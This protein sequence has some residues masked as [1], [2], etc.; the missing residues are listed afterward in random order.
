MCCSIRTVRGQQPGGGKGPSNCPHSTWLLAPSAQPRSLLVK[1]PLRR[2]SHSP[3]EASEAAHYHLRCPES[4]FG[5]P[6]S[7]SNAM[8]LKQACKQLS[9][10]EHTLMGFMTGS[11]TYSTAWPNAPQA[12]ADSLKLPI[13]FGRFQ[14]INSQQHRALQANN[15]QPTQSP[16]PTKAPQ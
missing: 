6:P 8:P 7:K 12:T 10:L 3:A 5:L 4:C 2:C 9:H 15:L 1:M 13:T 14:P 11:A 16:S